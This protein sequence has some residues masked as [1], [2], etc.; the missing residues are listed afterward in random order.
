[1]SDKNINTISYDSHK[2]NLQESFKQNDL[3]PTKSNNS[4]NTQSFTNNE[5]NQ[6]NFPSKANYFRQ[7][8]AEGIFRQRG[9]KGQSENKICGQNRILD[10]TGV[11]LRK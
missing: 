2:N 3:S 9:L 6:R 10:G 5:I 7:R 1:M 4:T 8:K 11:R